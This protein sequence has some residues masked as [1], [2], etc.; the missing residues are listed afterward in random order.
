MKDLLNASHDTSDDLTEIIQRIPTLLESL[1]KIYAD[2]RSI[3]L[4][5]LACRTH[6]LAKVQKVASALVSQRMVRSVRFRGVRD[7]Y[8][9]FSI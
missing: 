1:E 2:D 6:M 7:K 9:L 5:Q 3:E 8:R 4:Q